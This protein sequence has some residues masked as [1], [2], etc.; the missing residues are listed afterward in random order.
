MRTGE[1]S[2]CGDA[3][4]HGQAEREGDSRVPEGVGLVGDHRRSWADGDEHEGAEELGDVATNRIPHVAAGPRDLP[5]E[6]R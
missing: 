1:M 6:R 4:R 5:P 2:E 3:E